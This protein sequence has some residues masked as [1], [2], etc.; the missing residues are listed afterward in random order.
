MSEK[1]IIGRNDPVL[2]TGAGGFIGKCVLKEILERGFTDVRCFVRP[3]TSA[4]KIES[5]AGEE[6]KKNIRVIKGN[7]LSKD[8]CRNAVK[9]VRVIY[10]LAAG[11]GVK[12]FADAFFNTVVTT[13]NLLEAAVE[14]GVVE[15]FVNVSSFTVYDTTKR[16]RRQL[17][18]ETCKTE[19]NSHLR[20]EAY[21]FA[22]VKQEEIVQRYHDQRGLPF[23]TVRPGVVY[24]SGNSGLSGRVGMDTFGF[25]M[26]LGGSNQIPLTYVDNCAQA[27]VLSGL[28][29][30]VDGEIFNVVDDNPPKSR[31]YL[32]LYKSKTGSFF[33]VPVPYPA[34]YFFC[35]LWE[36]YVKWSQEQLPPAFNRRKCAAYWKGQKY[37][38]LKLKDKLG[39][40]QKVP[41]DRAIA[42]TFGD[43]SDS[44]GDVK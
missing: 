6:R 42:K 26:H 39:W 41:F 30:G 22:K 11:R 28:K 38:N 15:R 3:T 7:L 19:I 1:W 16:K 29:A 43:T 37:S 10:H 5:I 13:R 36:K 4:S 9:D 44:S 21:C 2:I 20:G 17:L 14:N 12:S 40:S 35:L 33:S 31:S 27:I 24:G 23:V 8:D 32:R 18:D 25:F 34:W